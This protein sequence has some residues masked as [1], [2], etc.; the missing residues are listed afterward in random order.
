M[1]EWFWRRIRGQL[2]A[3]EC[4]RRE[5]PCS[6]CFRIATGKSMPSGMLF[7]Q[8]MAKPWSR[9]GGVDAGSLRGVGGVRYRVHTLNYRRALVA[10]HTA[11]LDSLGCRTWNG[12][13]CCMGL[14]LQRGRHMNRVGTHSTNTS[15]LASTVTPA[16][17]ENV[18]IWSGGAG[19]TN[20]HV[21]G[22]RFNGVVGPTA[23]SPRIS[24][25]PVGVVHPGR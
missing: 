3:L 24:L 22:F 21:R 6:N 4:P 8:S 15:L 18:L 12:K 13:L 10:N 25:R 20:E 5:P 1:F 11:H 16:N 2:C 23:A 7:L 17:V 9:V 14:S 19:G